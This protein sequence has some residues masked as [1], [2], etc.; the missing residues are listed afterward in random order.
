MLMLSFVG[1]FVRAGIRGTGC[2][3][4]LEAQLSQKMEPIELFLISNQAPF[5]HL[6]YKHQQEREGKIHTD[7]LHQLIPTERQS[8]CIIKPAI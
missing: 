2:K 6:N 4:F 3:E 1:S 5:I 7:A 8:F